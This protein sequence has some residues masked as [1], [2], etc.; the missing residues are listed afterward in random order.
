M[1]VYDDLKAALATVQRLTAAERTLADHVAESRRAFGQMRDPVQELRERLLRLETW[2]EGLDEI[3]TT[4]AQA[5]AAAAASVGLANAL[6]AHAERLS[7]IETQLGLMDR[8]SRERRPPRR[9]GTEP[10]GNSP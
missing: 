2:F 7:V 1:G 4:R 9:I 5:A 3:V 6:L 10:E 8:P